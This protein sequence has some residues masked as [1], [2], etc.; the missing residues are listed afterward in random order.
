[1]FKINLFYQIFENSVYIMKT[2]IAVQTF[3]CSEQ[4]PRLNDHRVQFFQKI[5]F[6]VFENYRYVL[7]QL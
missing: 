6:Q 4:W 3:P 1:M 2:V 5:S 7:I